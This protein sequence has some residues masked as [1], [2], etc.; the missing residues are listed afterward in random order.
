MQA[1]ASVD[2]GV[3]ISVSGTSQGAPCQ[4]ML[5]ARAADVRSMC[6]RCAISMLLFSCSSFQFNPAECCFRS[7]R[8]SNAPC[9]RS[10]VTLLW[11]IVMKLAKCVVQS[12]YARCTALKPKQLSRLL[13]RWRSLERFV[14]R[15]RWSPTAANACRG[16]C[17]ASAARCICGLAGCWS[18]LGV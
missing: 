13:A 17:G 5:A 9:L 10:Y 18:E 12:R 1:G 16:L 4:D 8:L 14:Q 6:C 7:I 2:R 15:R 11:D 3:V